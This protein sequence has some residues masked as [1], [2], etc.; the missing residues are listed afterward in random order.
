M[1]YLFSSGSY[2]DYSISAIVEGPSDGYEILANAISL[3]EIEVKAARESFYEK[4][5][6]LTDKFK[7]TNP[8]PRSVYLKGR[9]TNKSL[10]TY[11]KWFK[12]RS[13]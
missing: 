12:K 4:Q 5:R 1:I 2:S 7:L 11:G 9:K 3:Y 13:D 6:I 8:E 10:T